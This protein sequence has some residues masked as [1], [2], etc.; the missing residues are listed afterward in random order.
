MKLASIL[1][2]SYNNLDGLYDT[3]DSVF[4]QDYPDIELVIAD[5]ASRD[6]REKQPALDAYIG[7]HRTP[8]IRDV[9][10]VPHETNGGT[11]KNSND[12]IRASHGEYL[13]ALASEDTLAH[14]SALSHMIQYLADSGE[15]VCF[16]RVRGI[17]PDGEYVDHLL[18]CES[19]YARLRSY[20]V[21]QTRNRLFARNFLPGACALKTRKLYEEY[22]LYPES[23]RLIEDYPFW[24][25]LTRKGVRFVYLD[26]VT[27]L[28]RLSGVS[29]TGHY[30]EMFMRDMYTIYEGY[31]FPYDHRYG[32]LQGIYNRLKRLGLDYYMALARWE[33][34]TP[35]ARLLNRVRYFPFFVY[36]G[37]QRWSNDRKNR[38]NHK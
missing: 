28:Y 17:T 20:T 16:G 4:R 26:E 1:I 37:L 18:S 7:S 27:V 12:A 9:I 25:E 31:I 38:M 21:E 10:W 3:L 36:T 24:L 29:S 33:K 30:S 32:A 2:L 6:Y 11:V 23:V 34:L 8:R 15:N 35:G 14:E 5:D 22:G 13:L 19:D